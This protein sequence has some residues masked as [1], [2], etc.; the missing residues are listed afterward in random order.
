MLAGGWVC[1][2][3][4]YSEADVWSFECCCL[5]ASC[6]HIYCVPTT[7]DLGRKLRGSCPAL[8]KLERH[9]GAATWISSKQ[10]AWLSRNSTTAFRATVQV[11]VS[12][13]RLARLQTEAPE[14]ERFLRGQGNRHP[15]AEV[16]LLVDIPCGPFHEENS[17]FGRPLLTR[18]ETATQVCCAPGQ[19]RA[20]T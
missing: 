20:L 13:W 12:L 19:Q 9:A 6:A 17:M 15:Q 10:D 7:E 18:E 3:L 14:E 11:T 2:E 1:F 16:C 4:G 8:R 5:R